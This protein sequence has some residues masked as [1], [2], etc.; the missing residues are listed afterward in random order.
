MRNNPACTG[1][2]LASGTRNIKINRLNNRFWL[3]EC[4]VF[5]NEH[6]SIVCHQ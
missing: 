5:I 3:T 4:E 6:N 1:V 2:N